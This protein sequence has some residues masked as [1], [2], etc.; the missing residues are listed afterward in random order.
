MKYSLRLAIAFGVFA[1]G[2]GVVPANELVNANLDTI[3]HDTQNNPT[4]TGWTVEAFKV[5]SGPHFDGCSSEPWC[6]VLEPDGYGLFFKPFQGDIGDEISVQF[7]QD[8]AASP[9]AKYI[10]S[11]YA[12]GEANYCGF[13][14]TNNPPPETLFVIQFLDAGNTV[15]ASN[16]F[17]LVAAGLPDS[18]PASMTL[19]TM[20]EVTAPANAVTVR[21]GAFMNNAHRTTNPQN[22][23]VD[24]FDLTVEAPAGAPV[25]T[26]QPSHTS[27]SPGESATFTVGVSNTLG[28]TYQWQF[29]GTNLSNGGNI[30]GVS[31]PMLTVANA[32]ASDVGPYRVRV[33]NAGGSVTSAEAKL[34]LLEISL[35]P[36]LSLTGRIGDTYRIDY[37][38]NLDPATWILLRTIVLTASPQLIVDSESPM[39]MRRFYRAVLVQ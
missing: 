34:S 19:F 6:N 11:G 2:V 12:A 7:Y 31:T 20:P 38:T 35:Y 28:V 14:P 16:A 33:T 39:S 18:G 27:V 13:F 10:L 26:N 8:V 37:S 1:L 36:V 32:S 22:F 23:F 17:D 3:A 15:I 24:A 30:S 25:I 29:F 4:P 21:A 5:L 9:G